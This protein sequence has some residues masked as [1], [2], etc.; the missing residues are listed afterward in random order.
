MRIRAVASVVAV[1]LTGA[2]LVGCTPPSRT[3]AGSSVTVA[4]SGAFTSLNADSSFGRASALNADIASLTG[5]GFASHDDRGAL[6]PDPSFGTATI[7]ARDPLTVRYTI[8]EG[9]TWSDGV[10]VTPDDLLLAWAA[11]SGALDTPDAGADASTDPETGRVGPLP[12]GVVHFDAAPPHGLELA[13]QTP[14]FGDDGRSLFVHFDSYTAGWQTVLAPGLPLHVVA[15]RALQLPLRHDAAAATD[16]ATADPDRDAAAGAVRAARA[17]ILDRD[18]GA[19]T[20]IAE[21]W[22]RGFD[23]TGGTPEPELLAAL[24]PYRVTAVADGSVTLTANPR[25]E[26]SRRPAIETITLTTV[27]DPAELTRRFAAGRLD[28][29]TPVP[30][31]A[32]AASLAAIPGVRVVPG[33]ASTLE[34]LELQFAD[35]RNGLFG[36]LRVRQAFLAVVPRQQILDEIVVPVS[37]DERLLDSFVL[38]PSDE[39]YADAIAGNGAREHAGVDVE[40]AT[41]LLASAGLVSPEVCILY[42]PA[43][44]R[45]AAEFALIRDSAQRAGFR[46][47]DC[48]RDDWRGLLG[49]AGA[50]D[51]ALYAWDTTRLGPSAV[52]AVYRSDSAVAN[53]THFADPQADGLID[54]LAATD[55]PAQRTAL[56]TQLDALLWQQAYGLPLFAHPVLT[57]VSERVAG[58]TRSPLAP[59]VLEHAWAWTPVAP[60][61]S[62]RTG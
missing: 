53:F 41:A 37:P 26:G 39:G 5:S 54:R 34:H 11:E 56:L 47:T 19:L 55:D 36:E 29:A 32:L 18:T 23:L 10:P 60:G 45:R 25:Y 22:N 35:S 8:A 2:A 24:G 51:A 4:V 50:Y 49:V 40:A 21:V 30:D 27:D 15:A 17:A 48:S 14:Q 3:V 59:G 42:D 20:R 38:R 13:R 12:E 9:V 16:T 58:V 46:V 1:V 6:V 43:D 31:P 44:A 57:V 28:V 52:S 61:G 62:A 33:A 7:T